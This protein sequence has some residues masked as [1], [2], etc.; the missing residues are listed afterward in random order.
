MKTYKE[1]LRD[2]NELLTPATSNLKQNEQHYYGE[3]FPQRL[4]P[5]RSVEEETESKD[6]YNMIM[7]N[8]E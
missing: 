3:K 7:Q 8:G 6:N 4:I 1:N 2:V 5:N